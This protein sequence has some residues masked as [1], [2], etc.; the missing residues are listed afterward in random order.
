[1][2][3]SNR[4]TE[5]NGFLTDDTVDQ[6]VIF[7]HFFLWFAVNYI[8]IVSEIYICSVDVAV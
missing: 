1:M 3:M 4:T 5:T 7:I 8:V 2:V 6:V